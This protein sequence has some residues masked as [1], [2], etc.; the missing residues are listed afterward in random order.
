M[1]CRSILQLW[2]KTSI[3]PKMGLSNTYDM[4]IWLSKKERSR[5]I[6]VD[7]GR[8]AT[9]ARG[10]NAA[11]E[12]FPRAPYIHPNAFHS[13]QSHEKFVSR[14]LST[15]LDPHACKSGTIMDSESVAFKWAIYVTWMQPEVAHNANRNPIPCHANN[16]PSLYR[17]L[18]A[19]RSNSSFF[20]MA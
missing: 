6:R 19:T 12:T 20:L 14:F 2:R 5:I 1:S 4:G 15:F 17:L 8:L 7:C 13:F 3:A 11:R 9:L 16:P 10:L 18:F